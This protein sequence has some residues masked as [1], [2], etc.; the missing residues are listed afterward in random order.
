VGPTCRRG[1][2]NRLGNGSGVTGWAEAEMFAGPDLLPEALFYFYFL[3]FFS[4]SV[5]L[6]LLYLLQK[7]F[8]INSNQILNSS[9]I[10]INHTKQ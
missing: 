4:F 10:Q 1:E 6:F 8:Q 9:N 7:M 5:F 3:F 2:E